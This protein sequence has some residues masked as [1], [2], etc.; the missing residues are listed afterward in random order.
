MDFTRDCSLSQIHR[1]LLK[2]PG[3]T[4]AIGDGFTDYKLYESG[5]CAD[6]IAYTEHAA[7]DKVIAVA[8]RCAPDAVTLWKYLLTKQCDSGVTTRASTTTE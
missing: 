4:V 5:I 6:F 8:P 2:T 1:T 7:R 3:R